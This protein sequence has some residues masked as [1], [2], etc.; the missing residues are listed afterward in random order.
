MLESSTGFSFDEGDANFEPAPTPNNNSSWL[1]RV[2]F[3]LC[4]I[5][6]S[7]VVLPLLLLWG[8]I[9]WLCTR[10]SKNAMMI[11][12]MLLVVLFVLIFIYD[13]S[14]NAV[15]SAFEKCVHWHRAL[16]KT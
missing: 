14:R 16:T 11:S 9:G 6:L 15:I 13:L 12:S 5:L 8:I 4:V 3:G 10:D 1:H 2:L 7:L